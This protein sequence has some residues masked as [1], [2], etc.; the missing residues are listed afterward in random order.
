M[1]LVEFKKQ[2]CKKQIGQKISN[3]RSSYECE[4]ECFFPTLSSIAAFKKN[5]VIWKFHKYH[6]F[7]TRIGN[8]FI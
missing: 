1:L 3:V 4:C 6:K 7:P 8:P 2:K 5:S